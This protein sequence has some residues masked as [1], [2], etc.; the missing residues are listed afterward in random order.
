MVGLAWPMSGVH[1]ASP[2]KTSE[3][4]LRVCADPNNLPFSNQQRQGFE[5]Q[6]AALL[7]R[8]LRARLEYTWAAQRRGFLRQTLGSGACDLVVGT[9][10]GMDGVETTRPYYRSTHVFVSRRPDR[11]T[12]RS[13]DD[14]RL[15]NVRVGAHVAG[16]DYANPAPLLALAR[17]HIIGNVTGFSLYGSYTEPNPPA[18]LVEAVANGT[19]D[20][21][22]AWGPIGGYFATK[23]APPLHV[24]VMADERD[25]RAALP[26]AFDISMAVR[27]RDGSCAVIQDVM[28]R[29][30]PEIAAILR[31]FGVPVL[32]PRH[33]SDGC[34]REG[35]RRD[36]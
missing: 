24:T 17:R 23:Q 13:I 33:G 8:E 15:A 2:G 32:P 25:E 22:I 18:R 34:S 19:V 29:R 31:S 21:A 7:A 3:R 35:G 14:P 28:D 12:I 4:I 20:V 11:L 16:D 5:N 36:H 1:S 26:F 10:H 30:S 27:Q 6:I 9:V